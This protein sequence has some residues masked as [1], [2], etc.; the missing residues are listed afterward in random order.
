MISKKLVDT[1]SKP[2]EGYFTIEVI[3]KNTN[4]VID[5][6]EFSNKIMRDSKVSMRKAM[7]GETVGSGDA[8]MINTLVLGT[9]GHD[10]N[11]LQPKTFSYDLSDIFAITEN[12]PV[13]PITFDRLGSIINEGYDPSM[14]GSGVTPT[15]LNIYTET[16][17]DNE[18]IVYEFII[19]E[20]SANNNGNPIAYTEAGL[21][22]NVD[23][24][25]GITDPEYG[26]IFA[27][28][29]FPAKIKDASTQLKITWRIIF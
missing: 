28:R 1:Y 18:S 19:S 7:K 12:Q 4:E 2:I 21:Y 27:M 26:R 3:D 14:P 23:Q 24:N 8:I 11:L 5:K 10:G 22:T 6:Y 16:S 29:T 20:D 9:R 15:I 13:Y 25:I 17:S